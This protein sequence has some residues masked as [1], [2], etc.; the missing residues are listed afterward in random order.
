MCS[1]PTRDTQQHCTHATDGLH[2]SQRPKNHF[3]GSLSYSTLSIQFFKMEIWRYMYVEY[4]WIP[5]GRTESVRSTFTGVR[6]RNFVVR[7]YVRSTILFCLQPAI[8]ARFSYDYSCNRNLSVYVCDGQKLRFNDVLYI[9]G[10]IDKPIYQRVL[11][12]FKA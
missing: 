8:T 3:R 7:P 9:W 10:W 4:V 6:Y 1:L 11:T 5:Y 2:V 12:C